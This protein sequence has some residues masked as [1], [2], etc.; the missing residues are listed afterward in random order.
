AEDGALGSV[1]GHGD[2]T[3]PALRYIA[4]LTANDGTGRAAAVEEENG[5]LAALQCLPQGGTEGLAENTGVAG[6]Q[7]GPQ[8]HQRNR[9]QMW[10]RGAHGWMF[11]RQPY[12][13]DRN[14]RGIRGAH[15]LGH[16]QGRLKCRRL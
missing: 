4:T 12:H 10:W 7:F 2:I 8:V 16:S 6:A 1:V 9:R 3:A 5:L 13:W 11:T 14:R 15:L